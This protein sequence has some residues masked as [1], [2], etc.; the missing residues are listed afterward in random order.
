MEKE[1]KKKNYSI[2]L[3]V[4]K[5]GREFDKEDFSGAIAKIAE[6]LKK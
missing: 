3:N 6:A 5:K 4:S 1:L 2:I